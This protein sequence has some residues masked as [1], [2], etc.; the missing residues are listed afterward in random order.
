MTNKVSKF[1]VVLSL[2]FIVSSCNSGSSDDIIKLK[3]DTYYQGEYQVGD[4]LDTENYFYVNK[5]GQET[6]TIQYTKGNEFVE[7][8]LDG[9]LFYLEANGT[10]TITCTLGKIKKS[11]SIE[12][13]YMTP[14]L[15]IDDNPVTMSYDEDSSI[16]FSDVLEVAAPSV[17]PVTCDIDFDHVEYQ[18]VSDDLD[19]TTASYRIIDDTGFSFKPV[20][21]GNYRVYVTSTNGNKTSKGYI[22]LF[23]AKYKDGNSNVKVSDYVD[24]YCSNNVIC[25]DNN[26]NLFTLPKA[27][28][29]KEAFVALKD[30]VNNGEQISIR[31]KGK[32]LPQI[33]IVYDSG[34]DSFAANDSQGY[35]LSFDRITSNN[36]SFALC[37]PQ[38]YGRNPWKSATTIPEKFRYEDFGTDDLDDDKYYYLTYQMDVVHSPAQTNPWWHNLSWSVHEIEDYGTLNEH[39]GKCLQEIYFSGWTETDE[40]AGLNGGYPCF[41]SS[42]KQDVTFEVL[43]TKTLVDENMY[44][45]DGAKITNNTY[46]LAPANRVRQDA[47]YNQIKTSYLGYKG[48]FGEGTT[49]CT[50]FG[51]TEIKNDKGEVIAQLPDIPDI[52][53]FADSFGSSTNGKGLYVSS[54]TEDASL[55]GRLTAYQPCRFDCLNNNHITDDGEGTIIYN[56]GDHTKNEYTTI[57]YNDR[58]ATDGTYVAKEP[59]EGV[60]SNISKVNILKYYNEQNIKK[61]L[62]KSTVK[63]VTENGINDYKVVLEFTLYSVNDDSNNSY[64]KLGQTVTLTVNNYN[65]RPYGN[66]IIYPEETLLIQQDKVKDQTSYENLL[67]HRAL[68]R[69]TEIKAYPVNYDPTVGE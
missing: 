34:G 13:E 35:F 46:S 47:G 2:G 19:P 64:E 44:L 14:I 61:F 54:G 17:L 15:N 23:L 50:E 9:H 60:L 18:P 67:Y 42:T 32:N 25:H 26:P 49:V 36:H 69:S 1:L 29:A 56:H 38:I 8:K 59:P 21:P 37:S 12:V 66:I 65:S 5:R 53:F 55:R 39:L 4:L 11:K 27:S 10:H 58:A 6:Y 33:G 40:K 51:V 22:N 57:G 20:G 28:Q 24:E 31:F 62:L 48:N 7:K 30:K 68:K 43:S 41:Y 63:S 3:E 45:F 16:R 52:C